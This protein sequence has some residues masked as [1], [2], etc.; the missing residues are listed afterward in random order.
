MTL[1]NR[2]KRLESEV[3]NDST[4]CAC[5]PQFVETYVRDL[6][7]DALTNEPVLTSESRPDICP[8]CGKQTVKNSITINLVD[9]TTKE[10]FPEEWNTGNK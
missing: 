8:A 3:I 7:I 1:K 10:R 9:S 5:Y 4:V 6:S 2:I